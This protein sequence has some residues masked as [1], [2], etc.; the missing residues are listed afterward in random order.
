M[1][2]AVPAQD[3]DAAWCRWVAC[4]VSSPQKLI[5]EIAAA[6][7]R[8]GV[9]IFHE[10]S[11]YAT[12]SFCP[13]LPF[14]EEFVQQVIAN[15]RQSGGEPDI[16]RQL[17]WHFE[18]AELQLISAVPHVYCARPTDY[19]WQWPAAFVEIGLQRLLDLGRVQK[20]W[21]DQVRGEFTEAQSNQRSLMITPTVLELVAKKR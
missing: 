20:S 19:L 13:P 11:H 8:R 10:Y 17:P 5:Q 9:T 3:V 18:Q 14:F 15:W 1:E 4:F 16:G 12:W 7:R 6:L 2:E 21:A